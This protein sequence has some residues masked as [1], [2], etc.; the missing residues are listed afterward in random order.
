MKNKFKYFGLTFSLISVLLSVQPSYAY[1]MKGVRCVCV[2]IMPYAAPGV[3]NN[4]ECGNGGIGGSHLEVTHMMDVSSAWDFVPNVTN[5]FINREVAYD[6]YTGW[7][8]LAEKINP[9]S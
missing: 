9:F 3:K 6:R 2:G 5:T 8:C 1:S 7:L 4:P